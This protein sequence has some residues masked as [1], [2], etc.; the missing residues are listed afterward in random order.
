M[1]EPENGYKAMLERCRQQCNQAASEC[2]ATCAKELR[3]CQLFHDGKI[4]DLEMSVKDRESADGQ[5]DL[6]LKGIDNG[7]SHLNEDTRHMKEKTIPE[8][9]VKL[10]ATGRRIWTSGVIQV[11]AVGAIMLLIKKY[12]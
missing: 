4:H 6:R 2:K 10:E 11:L 8:L 5:Q 3:D 12:G 1:G 9:M 7:L